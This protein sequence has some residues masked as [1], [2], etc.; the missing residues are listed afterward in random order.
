MY[1]LGNVAELS[2]IVSTK[3]ILRANGTPRPCSPAQSTT[4]P[5]FVG[6]GPEGGGG[7]EG[8]VPHASVESTCGGSVLLLDSCPASNHANVLPEGG[9]TAALRRTRRHKG[10]K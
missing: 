7:G 2:V 8:V 6:R 10:S 3:N 5:P 1:Q 4:V 9:E